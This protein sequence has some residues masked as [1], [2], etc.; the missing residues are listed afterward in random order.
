MTSRD[1]PSCH[2]DAVAVDAPTGTPVVALVGNPNVGKSTLFNRITGEG[3]DVGNW[4]GTTVAVGRSLWTHAALGSAVVI[5]LPGAVSLDPLSPDEQLTRDLLVDRPVEERPD[6]VVVVVS[7]VHLARG[8]YLLRQVREL[9]LRT[10]VAVTMDDLAVRRGLHVDVDA[11]AA[12]CGSP[13]LLVDPRR[14]HGEDAL[15]A[16]V[17]QQL[18]TPAPP[19]TSPTEDDELEAAE[20]RFAWVGEVVEAATTRGEARTSWSD[21]LDRITTARWIGPL[22]FLGV[23]W[24]L[25]Q[26]TTTVAAPLQG[27]LDTFVTGPVSA[28]ATSLLEAVGLGGTWVQGLVVDG[29]IAG[30]GM[31]LTFVPLMAVMFAFL[32]VLEDSGYLARAA[33]VTDRTMRAIGLPG[34]AFLPLVVGFG[35]NVPAIS[36]TRVL[37]DARHRLLTAL[38]VPFTSCSARLTVYVL[39]ATTFFGDRAGTVVFAMYVVSIVLVVLVGLLLRGTLLRT[40]GNDPLVLDLPPYQVPVVRLVL[41]GTWRRL[42]GFL[43]TASGIIVVTVVIVWALSATPAPG[44]G[45]TFGDVPVQDSVY[46][47]AAGRVAPVFEPAGFGSWESTSALMVGFVAKEAVISSW[48]QTFATAEPEAADQ[49]GS[50]GTALQ[51]SFTE[52][53]GGH[54]IPAVLAFLVFLLAYTPC[55]ATLAAQRREIGLRWTLTGVA[56]QLAIAWVLAVA[57]FQVGVALS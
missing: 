33:V 43:R 37:P 35:C 12:A 36:G 45:G 22:L 14:G 44:S 38:L 53:S 7:A 46:A 9:G 30:V 17:A 16:L 10:V 2:S 4:P 1:V 54:P 57:I 20:A 48:A 50:L 49:P 31:L 5:D 11:L 29:L 40:M 39:V 28:A 8:V 51:A 26:A 52:S 21:R 18:A 55:V 15:A 34:R 41:Q 6:L 24:V 32:S 47:T 13:A 27:A 56:M 25:F 42:R 23:M 3:R 19:P